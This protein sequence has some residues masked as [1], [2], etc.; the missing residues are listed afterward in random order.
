MLQGSDQFLCHFRGSAEKIQP[1]LPR[2]SSFPDGIDHH[3]GIRNVSVLSRSH[4][5]LSGSEADA[6]VDIQRLGDCLLPVN[7]HQD[8]LAADSL[9]RQCVCRMGTHMPRPENDD[10]AV[11]HDPPP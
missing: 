11:V 10:L 7:I 2:L 4:K 5:S 8:D 3:R 6:V 9:L 1:C